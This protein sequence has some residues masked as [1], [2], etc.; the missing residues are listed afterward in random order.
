MNRYIMLTK[1]TAEGARTLHGQPD[2]LLAVNSEVSELGCTVLEQYATLGPYDFVN[3]IEA[4]DN[5][6]MLRVAAKLGARGTMQLLTMPAA[7]VADFVGMLKS[8][9]GPSRRAF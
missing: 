6:T 1:L 9:A 2:R 4:P 7:P 3:V 8:G 5:E